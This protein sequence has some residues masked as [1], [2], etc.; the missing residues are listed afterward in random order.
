MGRDEIS[1]QLTTCAR[2]PA[3]HVCGHDGGHAADHRVPVEPLRRPVAGGGRQH[4]VRPPRAQ[5]AE[6]V[7][8]AVSIEELGE[9][10][11]LDVPEGDPPD[12]HA[13]LVLGERQLEQRTRGQDR[14]LWHLLVEPAQLRENRA[15]RLY[16]I[17]EEEA[18]VRREVS[19]V[20][21][22]EI[23]Q[24]PRGV[25]RREVPGPRG[26]PLEVDLDQVALGVGGEVAH[27]PGLPDLPGSPQDQGATFY[28]I[29][30]DVAAEPAWAGGTLGRP[31]LRAVRTDRSGRAAGR[32]S[33]WCHSRPSA[34]PVQS[35]DPE[36]QQV[37]AVG[38]D[39]RRGFPSG[40][41]D[42]LAQ[43]GADQRPSTRLIMSRPFRECHPSRLWYSTGGFAAKHRQGALTCPSAG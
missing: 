4:P 37:A 28:P 33:A 18:P 8:L 20:R 35:G 32:R 6:Q 16:L 11:R 39:E 27:Q 42:R 25:A 23:G 43:V 29:S 10:H 12:R 14:K 7:L 13:E 17:E 41:V 15:G 19:P 9:A 36:E 30:F 26:I 31:P 22:G 34:Q 38:R 21:E 3:T 40:G 1:L 2:T 5:R 24:H